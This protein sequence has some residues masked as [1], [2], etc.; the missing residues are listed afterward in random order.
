MYSIDIVYLEMYQNHL[1]CYRV[2]HYIYLLIRR[3]GLGFPYRFYL[4]S[5]KMYCIYNMFSKGH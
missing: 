2:V 1:N 5:E 3:I 4:I